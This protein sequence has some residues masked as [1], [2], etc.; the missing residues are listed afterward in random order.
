[1]PMSLKLIVLPLSLQLF[2]TAPYTQKDAI[3]AGCPGQYD[4]SNDYEAGDMVED[5]QVVYTCSGAGAYCKQNAP[6][7]KGVGMNSWTP[8]NSCTGTANPTESP[9]FINPQEGCPEEFDSGTTYEAYDRPSGP[10]IDCV[11]RNS[12][13]PEV[14]SILW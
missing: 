10:R 3:T 14:P 13:V 6:N 8:I 9:V 12:G 5:N 2:Q 4:S 7:L 1:M 11:K